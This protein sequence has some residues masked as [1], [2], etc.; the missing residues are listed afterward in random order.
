MTQE[1]MGIDPAYTSAP[2]SDPPDTS[3]AAVPWGSPISSPTSC[4]MLVKIELEAVSIC[5]K[6]IWSVLVTAKMS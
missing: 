4:G 2:W 3:E 6:R 5:P 1:V